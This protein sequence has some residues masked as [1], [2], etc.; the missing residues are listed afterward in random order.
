M[1]TRPGWPPRADIWPPGASSDGEAA[2]SE[3]IVPIARHNP[4]RVEPS[5][6]PVGPSSVTWRPGV[7]VVG[8]HRSGT[9]VTTSALNRLGLTLGD[10]AD[11]LAGDWSNPDGH[12]ESRRLLAFNDKL[13]AAAGATWR[14]IPADLAI[15]TGRDWKDEACRVFTDRAAGEPWV[16]KDPRLCLL[17]PF[18]REVFSA[19]FE[20]EPAAVLCL[21]NPLEVAA[22][23]QRRNGMPR[24][25]ALALWERY[26]DSALTALDGM[27]VLVSRYDYLLAERDSWCEAAVEFLRGQG[28][29]LALDAASRRAAGS[30]AQLDRCHHRFVAQDVFDTPLTTQSQR[31]LFSWTL[32]LA[33]SPE[34]HADGVRSVPRTA[35][36]R[37]AAGPCAPAFR[38]QE[39]EASAGRAVW[40]A[41]FPSTYGGAD[42]EL[43]H[44]VD[45][46]RLFDV[47]VNLVPLFGVGDMM[48]RS[49][50]ERGCRIHEYHPGIFADRVVL[51]FCNGEFLQ[52]LPDIVAAGRPRRVIWFNCMTWTFD[53]ELQAHE[54]GW[55]DLFGFESRYQEECLGPLL[56]DIAPYRTFDYRPYFNTARIAWSHRDFAGTYRVG[57]ISRDDPAK[58]ATDTWSIFDRVLVPAGL[59]KKVF[60]LG[61][62]QHA[63]AK[64]G[65]PPKGLDWLTWTPDAIGSTE[66]YRTIDTLMHKT[67]GSR[68]SYGR[69]VVEAYAH[70]VVPIVEDA[71][72]FPDL[73]VHGETG[74][75]AQSSDEMSHYAGLLAFDEKRH[76]EMARAG[77]EWLERLSDPEKCFRPWCDLL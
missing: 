77:R 37:A 34:F 72:A 24:Q 67:G 11:D 33:S 60:I 58:Y 22:S 52:R 42:T 40:V 9:S 29:D 15:P 68:E 16:W 8:M 63:A 69:V 19:L 56:A 5:L 75:R 35:L 55:I 13:L 48:R 6:H 25:Q 7:V 53:A 46:F 4:D 71:F 28:V 61:H 59:R 27:P 65:P 31:I 44:L 41:G 74:Y 45:L 21:R 47:D 20:A 36:P 62:G 2:L 30:A 54:K 10:A 64:I 43:D 17:L 38:V 73:V 14:D 32:D 51:S 23:L 1:V 70:G 39:G 18:W 66:F 3:G 12:W 26:L 50:L 76:E 57:R 49:V